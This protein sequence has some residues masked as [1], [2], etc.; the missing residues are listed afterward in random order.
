MPDVIRRSFC[1]QGGTGQLV[2]AGTGTAPA[3]P[4]DPGA[5]PADRAPPPF[6]FRAPARAPA[7]PRITRHKGAKS[8]RQLAAAV[9]AAPD[10]PVTLSAGRDLAHFGDDGEFPVFLARNDGVL[11]N[12]DG[13][14]R[15]R[16]SA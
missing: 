7:R 15:P 12:W 9:A 16:H 8:G 3:I 11:H 14:L 2:A 5:T 10:S 6:I 4:P 13:N 1:P